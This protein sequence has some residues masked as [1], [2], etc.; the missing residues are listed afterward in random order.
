MLRIDHAMPVYYQFEQWAEAPLAHGVFTRIGGV[1]E[2]PWA[3]LNVGGT[4]GDNIAHVQHNL[5]LIYD[6]LEVDGACACTVWQ[7]HSADVVIAEERAPGRQWLAR[8]DG[9][10]TNRVG[11]PLTMRFADC[12]PILFYDPVQ[13]AIGIAH[14]G[15]RG[16]VAQV[17]A[18][19]IRTMQLA[20]GTNP[21]DVQAAIGPSIGPEQYQ[22]GPEVVEAVR[23][24][25]G[26]AA[27]K[28]LVRQAQDGTF[29]LDLWAANRLGLERI[30]V[31]PQN[32]E[33][34]GLCTATHVDEF[35]SHRA[36]RGKTGRFCAVIALR[37]NE[38]IAQ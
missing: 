6:T 21:A 25:Y 10:V 35:F 5:R 17:G 15:W 2:S 33:V 14:A 31:Q 28:S 4:V 32:I 11:V 29:Y 23:Q 19:T 3:S 34:A 30:G 27:L 38:G 36:E 7:V 9:M 37:G 16:T 12:V 13:R 24:A 18:R 26:E 1:S 20:Y 22:V 8:A